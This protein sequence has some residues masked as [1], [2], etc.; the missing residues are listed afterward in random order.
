MKKTPK[1]S[2]IFYLM[3]PP[4]RR[5][6]KLL[7]SGFSLVELIVVIAIMAVMA[8]VLAPS[9]LKYTESSRKSKDEHSVDELANAVQLAL[10]DS[11]IYDE[12][13]Q[14]SAHN[15]VSCYIDT[16]TEAE[17]QTNKIWT[18]KDTVDSNKGEYTFSP[19]A[20]LLDETRYIAAGNMRGVTITWHPNEKQ[21]YTVSDGII[22]KW[23]SKKGKISDT[24]TLL[25][26]VEST[27]GKELG[28]SS[29]TYRNSDYTLFIGLNSTGG[30]AGSAQNVIK[31]YGQ[32][33]GTNLQM[34]DINFEKTPDRLTDVN[35]K[36][37]YP[38]MDDKTPVYD[39]DDL[40]GGGNTGGVETTKPH[41]N[42]KAKLSLNAFRTN[43]KKLTGKITFSL[44]KAL[45][46]GGIDVSEARDGSV[47]AVID[48]QNATIYSKY[49]GG[50][51]SP[52]CEEYI[53]L[54]MS[55]KAKELDLKGLDTSQMTN[56]S[57][58]FFRC[59]VSTLDLSTF[60]TSNVTTMQSMF[61]TMSADSVIMNGW[62][63]NKVTNMKSMFD[64]A[65]IIDHIDL[66]PL[67]TTNV[68]DMSYMFYYFQ[69]PSALDFSN[70]D[71][72]N[73]THMLMMFCGMS[74]I[75]ALD[76]SSFNTQNV[77]TMQSM[78][79]DSLIEELDISS[80][81]THNVVNFSFMFGHMSAVKTIYASETF[82]VT[83]IDYNNTNMFWG[84]NA[85][86]GGKGST[87]N[88][89]GT[90]EFAAKIDGINGNNGLFTKK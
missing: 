56:M 6:K 76:L 51:I 21:K 36:E 73:V 77:I 55:C 17:H 65:K 44:K 72:Q 68:V 84:C 39:E 80:F 25:A 90:S 34:S 31:I 30:K 59:D 79:A 40:A 47:L 42:P 7:K 86:V 49:G 27:V 87:I 18:K 2:K 54:F 75:K 9:L 70:F 15:N 33:D 67:R 12:L 50:V 69:G 82:V 11:K 24:K 74:K 35:I 28:L 16:K 85:L 23:M 57:Y 48:G 5:H 29:Q 19:D 64:N 4:E 78:F 71:T 1:C 45:A 13:V 62:D 8:A 58:M 20:R 53:G 3:P 32:F 37:E 88:K 63:T 89:T 22:N 52:N 10:A 43:C 81:D 46:S 26:R 83:E 66:S 38:F 61:E 14:Y 41:A 60:D